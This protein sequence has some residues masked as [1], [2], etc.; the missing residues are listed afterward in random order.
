VIPASDSRP[1]GIGP[2]I[3]QTNAAHIETASDGYG[4]VLPLVALSDARGQ[5]LHNQTTTAEMIQSR[6]RTPSGI[7]FVQAVKGATESTVDLMQAIVSSAL[8]DFALFLTSSTVM[9][10]CRI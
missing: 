6:R 2:Q 7:P 10:R 5:K 4:F 1:R 9:S 8:A 3:V